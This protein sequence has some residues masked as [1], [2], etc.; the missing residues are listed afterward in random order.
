MKIVFA[1][2]AAGG[3][4]C[5][6]T[7]PVRAE[8]VNAIRG[9]VHDSVITQ[10]EVREMTAEA[11]QLLFRQNR[12][13][14]EVIQKKVAEAEKENFEELMRR[15]L[16]LHEFKTAGY[17]LPES[18]L[19][20]L[21]NERIKAKYVD[22]RTLT[23]SLQAEG[24]TYEKYRQRLREEF[25]IQAMRQK[26]IA[27]EIIVSPH[28]VESYYLAHRDKFKV[29]DE[30][31]L[32]MIVLNKSTDPNGP[33]PGKLAEE[34]LAKLKDGAA[35]EEMANVYSQRQ[36]RTQGGEWFEKSQLRK[37]LA[38]AAGKLKV[39]EYSEVIETPEAIYLV[40]LEDVRP[41]HFRALTEVREQ[42]ERDLVSEERTRLYKQWVDRL[43]KKT[44]VKSY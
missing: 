25:I 7:L 41:S 1:I 37:E 21:V 15:Q 40:L 38:E 42:I 20:D 43:T 3:V 29:E 9:V 32:R 24:M 17:N 4:V 39:G 18:I 27:S 6:S 30:V 33:Q 22:R 11:A 14:D 28:K 10:Q 19:D 34:I 44:F 8:L 26:N 36:Q 5:A 2:L 13:Q 12:G 23:K 16:I 31:R 35:F